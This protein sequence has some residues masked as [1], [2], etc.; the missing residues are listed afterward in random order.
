MILRPPSPS[1]GSKPG[2]QGNETTAAGAA[3]GGA[4][5]GAAAGAGECG[6]GGASKISVSLQN[7]D[8]SGK[9]K[10]LRHGKCLPTTEETIE[11]SKTQL[12]A[13]YRRMA[14]DN[15]R[16]VPLYLRVYAGQHQRLSNELFVK[17]GERPASQKR[18]NLLMPLTVTPMHPLDEVD[19]DADTDSDA[20]DDDDYAGDAD[21]NNDGND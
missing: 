21:E 16:N 8:K 2:S 14:P 11:I 4:A 17:Y 15:V 3:A 13:F 10:V 6:D 9:T 20:N 7:N 12:T 18:T 1:Q 5:A 19:D